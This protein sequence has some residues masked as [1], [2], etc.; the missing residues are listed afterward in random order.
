M[1][2]VIMEEL[3]NS[4]PFIPQRDNK[5]GRQKTN[6]IVQ[7]KSSVD[8]DSKGGT[9]ISVPMATNVLLGVENNTDTLCEIFEKILRF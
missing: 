8:A 3:T 4:L 7:P 2:K 1:Y 5:I 6:D 9:Q